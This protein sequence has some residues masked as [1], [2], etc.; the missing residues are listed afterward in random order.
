MLYS[1]VAGQGQRSLD[2][3]DDSP[4]SFV[5]PRPDHEPS[6]RFE[7]LGIALIATPVLGDL[8]L[9]VAAVR[10]DGKRAVLRATVPV[11]AVDEDCDAA[12]RE[13]D[14]RPDASTAARLHLEINPEAEAGAVKGAP[15]GELRLGISTAIRPHDPAS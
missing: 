5:L 4:W 15:D 11:A 10:G 12:A 1:L 6:V 9:P 13:D 3:L 2:P 7:S 8:L 14:V